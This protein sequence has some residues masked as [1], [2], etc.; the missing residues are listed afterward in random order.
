MV[1]AG[2]SLWNFTRDNQ[3][4]WVHVVVA[5]VWNLFFNTLQSYNWTS[6]LT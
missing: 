4:F 6:V 1:Y 2:K 3:N 5:Y